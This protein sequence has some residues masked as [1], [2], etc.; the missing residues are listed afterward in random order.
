MAFDFPNAP[1]IGQKYPQP[2]VVGS[3]VYTWD[4]VKWTTVGAAVSGKTAVLNDGSV[5]MAAGLTLVAPPVNATDAAAK[6]YV[7]GV[8]R[9]T[10]GAGAARCAAGL[11]AR[12]NS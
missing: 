8:Q 2:P 11:Q 1:T 10:S 12:Q 9:P 5:P 6:S 4:G 7:D 3:P